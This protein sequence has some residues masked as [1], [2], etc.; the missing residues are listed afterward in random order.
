MD[1]VYAEEN[2]VNMQDT[3]SGLILAPGRT[4]S[5]SGSLEDTTEQLNQVLD[6]WSMVG[7][8]VMGFLALV[9][10]ALLIINITILAKSGDNEKARSEAKTRLLYTVIAIALFGAVGLITALSRSLF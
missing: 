3:G 9:L 10:L 1:A 8:A 5:L 7:K 4:P 6:R 2:G